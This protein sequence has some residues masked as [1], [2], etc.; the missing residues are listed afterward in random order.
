MALSPERARKIL[1]PWKPGQSGNPAGRGHVKT[2]K[3]AIL[4][5]LNDAAPDLLRQKVE[6]LLGK[7]LPKDITGLELLGL[8]KLCDAI[9]SGNIMAQETMLDRTE[10][11]VTQKVEVTKTDFDMDV[12]DD[13]VKE[14]PDAETPNPPAGV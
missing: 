5:Y 11:K 6:R 1:T 7:P 14:E 12:I 13:T 4:P 3:N 2:F 10:G 8:R 9:R